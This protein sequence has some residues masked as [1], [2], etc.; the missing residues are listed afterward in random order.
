[1]SRAIANR[2]IGRRNSLENL[3]RNIFSADGHDGSG[4]RGRMVALAD[5]VRSLRRDVARFRGMV[6]G[7][8]DDEVTGRESVNNYW[9]MDD[10]DGEYRTNFQDWAPTW[11]V[12][13]YIGA[14]RIRLL[15][16]RFFN[17]VRSLMRSTRLRNVR[18]S[19]A[20]TRG[21]NEGNVRR[22]LQFVY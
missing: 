11:S 3:V 18:T 13:E 8:V 2:E 22:Y 15:V 1:M 5:P 6:Q 14:H 12:R 9:Q 10:P 17:K 21:I 7:D 20:I 4:P 16:Q 19:R